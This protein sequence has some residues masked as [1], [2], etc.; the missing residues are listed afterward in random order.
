MN[1][2]WLKKAAKRKEVKTLTPKEKITTET[3][4]FKL[5]IDG[6]TMANKRLARDKDLLQDELKIAKAGLLKLKA[7]YE[8]SLRH[9]YALD[10]QELL[11]Y[12]DL[13]TQK[14]IQGKPL[15]EL[16]QM[17]ENFMRSVDAHKT[18]YDPT[19]IKTATIRPGTSFASPGDEDLTVGNLFGKTREEI[20]EMKGDF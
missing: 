11:G 20:R 19:K 1:A 8:A 15:D 3:D 10:I 14:L 13:E 7:D 5:R 4:K 18:P 16:A 2:A 17:R 12:S 6:L 9:T